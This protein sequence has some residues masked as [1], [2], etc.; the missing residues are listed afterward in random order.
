MCYQSDKLV[1]HGQIMLVMQF[2]Q[3]CT[4]LDSV[5]RRV[6][7]HG[8]SRVEFYTANRCLT[9]Q[10]SLIRSAAARRMTHF[11]IASSIDTSINVFKA[12]TNHK[13]KA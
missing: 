10:A 5:T 8:I 6:Y 12:K 2:A 13:K 9:W 1:E 4:A 3:L 7:L 11:E